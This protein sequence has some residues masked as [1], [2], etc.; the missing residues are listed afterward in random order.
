[1][2]RVL[3]G[4]LPLAGLVLALAAFGCGNGSN[5]S[6]ETGATLEGTVTYGDQKV[7]VGLVIVEKDGPPVTAFI[8]ETGHYKLE[9]VPLGEVRLAVNTDAG[10]GR[11]K[12]KAMARKKDDPPLPRVID[13][14]ARYAGAPMTLVK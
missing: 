12:S 5:Q 1:M 9:N 13:V 2:R 6:A 3:H 8:D 11:L 7:L 10:K 4:L 14:P